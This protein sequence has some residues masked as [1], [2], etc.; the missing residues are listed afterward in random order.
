MEDRCR[1]LARRVILLRYCN[2]VASDDCVA[3]LSLRLLLKRDSV[4]QDCDSRG[5][6]DDRT[7]RA[8]TRSI[9][10]RV[11]SRQGGAGNRLVRQIDGAL[12]LDWVH[13]ELAPYYSR[14]GRPSIDP[15]L[16]IRM[17]IVRRISVPTVNQILTYDG[18][19][20]RARAA[21]QYPQIAEFDGER[22]HPCAKTG[23]CARRCD[24]PW[25]GP[26]V[27]TFGSV[28][29]HYANPIVLRRQWPSDLIRLLVKR[30]P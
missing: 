14:T 13:K 29:C 30:C 9:L 27:A 7:A 21:P 25:A 24:N 12:H 18:A 28:M 6:V 26:L 2:S 11:Q 16:M 5:A 4:D 23:A 17:F 1:R 19:V 20:R 22:V 8:R 15:E 10:Q 3:K